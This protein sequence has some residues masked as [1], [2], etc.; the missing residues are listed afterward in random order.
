[1][2]MKG[3]YSSDDLTVKEVTPK[4]ISNIGLYQN[5]RDFHHN[6]N[7]YAPCCFAASACLFISIINDGL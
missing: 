6:S 7:N 5:H 2:R 3:F 4:V 1:M